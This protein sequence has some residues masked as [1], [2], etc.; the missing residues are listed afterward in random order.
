MIVTYNHQGRVVKLCNSMMELHRNLME[1]LRLNNIFAHSL[2]SDVCM[3]LQPVEKVLRRVRLGVETDGTI[4]ITAAAD[5]DTGATIP[6]QLE[7]GRC[8]IVRVLWD[9]TE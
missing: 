4:V 5:V 2:A 3:V 8:A 7:D 1:F 9:T 6:L